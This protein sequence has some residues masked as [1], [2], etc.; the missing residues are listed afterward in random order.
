[1]ESAIETCNG[2]I[3]SYNNLCYGYAPFINTTKS[4]F[5]VLCMKEKMSSNLK[6]IADLRVDYTLKSFNE[7]D[8]FSDPFAQFANWLDEAIEAQ[9]NEPNAMTLATVKPNGSPSARI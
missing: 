8:L 5:V 9:A 2:V 6:R 1:M 3:L 4:A 7:T